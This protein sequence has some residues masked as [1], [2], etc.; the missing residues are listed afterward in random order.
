[1]PTTDNSQSTRTKMLA[2]R[3]LASFKKSNPHLPQGGRYSFQQ[4]SLVYEKIGEIYNCCENP[5][6][7]I[8]VPDSPTL[9]T[10]T[11]GDNQATISF[12]APEND[13]GSPITSYTVISSP[14]NIV[15]TGLTSPITITGLD[16]GTLYTFTVV[17]TNEIGDSE[18]SVASTAASYS[19]V[20]DSPTSVTATGG[21]AQATVSFTAPDDNG[22]AIVSYTVTSS[23][24]N[25]T[26]T[27]SSSPITITGLTNGITYTFTVVATNGVGNSTP[28]SASNSV[29]YVTVPGPPTYV[30]ASIGNTQ[31]NVYFIPPVNNGGSTIT[32]Y[33]VTSSPDGITAT[34][35]SSPI[36]VTGLTNGTSYT[37]TVIATNS[38]GDSV[39]SSP[40]ST[41]VIDN[42][43]IVASLSTSLSDYQSAAADNWIKITS[44][45]YTNLQTNVIGT[46][47]SGIT[48]DYLNGTSSGGLTNPFSALVANS[49][50]TKSPAIPAN[51]YLYAFSVRWMTAEPAINMC[52]FTNTNSASSGGF[53]KV[54]GVLPT[55]TAAG[56][57]YYVRKGVF[58]TNG[59]TAGLL[60]CFTGTKLDYSN[61]N[62]PGSGAYV[63]FRYLVG[64]PP[65]PIMRYLLGGNSIPGA[66][67]TL[68]GS[69]S[70][71]GA[72]LIQGLTTNA[73]QWM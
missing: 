1:M 18:P 17:A 21:N 55:P 13:G 64:T 5:I 20:P 4:S 58:A 33:T 66:N 71:Y 67:V 22:S 45:E 44:G 38:E 11:M 24:G 42:D 48:T 57:S 39:P 56:L 30:V 16:N 31:S 60:A 12:T 53:N 37:F 73:M 43:T 27:G 9:V 47:L 40:S 14:D 6:P 63:G 19:S 59:T 35:S 49:V 46:T 3:E 23:P 29:V 36:T 61:N 51:E 15:V 54:G 8:T 52:V 26:A 41:F 32:S 70:N 10:A 62:F 69:L 34:G 25:I 65:I 72:F 68:T 7:T 2:G 50:T 28:S